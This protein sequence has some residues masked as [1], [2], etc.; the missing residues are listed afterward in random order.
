MTRRPACHLC[1]EFNAPFLLSCGSLLLVETSRSSPLNRELLFVNG[2]FISTMMI[3]GTKVV[4]TLVFLITMYGCESW[5]VKE[6][7]K[8]KI[9]LFENGISGELCG[10][11]GLPERETSGS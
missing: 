9:D 11:P 1:A 5:T 6:A 7:D 8:R 2:V 4:H 10:Y 3:V